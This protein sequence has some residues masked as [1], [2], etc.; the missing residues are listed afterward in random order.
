MTSQEP[1]KKYFQGENSELLVHNYA[2]FTKMLN[3]H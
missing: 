1:E 3:E 2:L